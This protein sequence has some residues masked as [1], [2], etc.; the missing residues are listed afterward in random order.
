MELWPRG[1]RSGGQETVLH[2]TDLRN[3][4]TCDRFV[5]FLPFQIEVKLASVVDCV[6]G[7]MVGDRGGGNVCVCVCSCCTSLENCSA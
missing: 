3:K 1:H 7:L 4:N 5:I 6:E 2:L